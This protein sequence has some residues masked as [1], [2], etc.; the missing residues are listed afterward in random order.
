M[1]ADLQKPTPDADG[2]QEFELRVGPGGGRTQR[3][4]GRLIAESQQV[5]KSG[6]EVVQVYLSRKGKFVVHRHYI[7][8]NDFLQ[9]GKKSYRE[10]KEA[11]AGARAHSGQSDF[12]VFGEWAKGLK[13]WRDLVGFGDGG[14]GDYTLDIV[15]TLEELRDRVPAKAFRIVSDVVH[16][17]AEEVLDI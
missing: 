17:P 10:Q 5:T 15:E 12:A 16:N 2:M 6:A 7:D 4:T 11:L 8:W 3:F 9:S 1:P 13:N 14:A